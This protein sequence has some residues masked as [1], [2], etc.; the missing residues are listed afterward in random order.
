MK[1]GIIIVIVVGSFFGVLFLS[2]AD[3]GVKEGAE[4]SDLVRLSTLPLFDYDGN[5][6]R[7]SDFE[8]RLLV[9]NS[10]AVWCPFCRKE[11][12]DFAR[13][14]EAFPDEIAVIA[15]DR[16]E[17][18]ERVK[19]FTDELGVSS[20]MAFLI[21]RDDAFYRQIGGFSMP[22]TVFINSDGAIIFHKR[23]PLTLEEMKSRVTELLTN[24]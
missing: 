12:P 5:E 22:E 7:L 20:S 3:R 15:I 18:L 10:W 11:L 13:L 16:A 14:Q 9:V 1:Q 21:D 17:S 23:G 8:E 2:L 19:G 4:E 6:V 24:Q